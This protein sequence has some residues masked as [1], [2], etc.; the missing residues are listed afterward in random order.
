MC[1]QTYKDV[2][3]DTS[4]HAKNDDGTTFKRPARNIVKSS[5]Y[6]VGINDFEYSIQ[7]GSGQHKKI[8]I[9]YKIWQDML[10][11]CHGRTRDVKIPTYIGVTCCKEWL[12]FSSFLD[13]LFSQPYY[14]KS[15]HLEKDLLVKGNRIY[16]PERVTL[17]PSEINMFLTNRR[18]SRN[19]L[20]GTYYR[21]QTER[22]LSSIHDG[23]K[24]K[25]LG[26]FATEIEAFDAYKKAKED[27]S[28][29]LAAKYK[30]CIDRKAY[31][32]L[33]EYSVSVDD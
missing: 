26:S 23:E 9:P 32:A 24:S 28:K 31:D 17:V 12:L 20:I 2:F 29:F 5:V 4:G 15:Y 6:R 10:Y 1:I 22:W 25:H 7:T 27:R 18:K 33:M 3:L 30:L 8:W 19:S 11:R 14:C 13:W 21:R 16:C